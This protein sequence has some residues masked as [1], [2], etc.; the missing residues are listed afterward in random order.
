MILR[1]KQAFTLVELMMVCVIIGILV[2]FAIPNYMRSVERS[3]CALAM[4]NLKTMRSAALGWYNV[5]ES[6]AAGSGMTIAALGT[7]AGATFAD[8]QNWA[9]T[10]PA[11]AINTFTFRATRQEGPHSG[12][13]ITINQ[14]ESWG[15]SYPI[16]DPGVW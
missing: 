11:Q 3:R 4:Q 7:F 9:Y 12:L 1:R 8:D 5:H 13:T 2:T 16:D 15:G 14:D 10:I 6:F